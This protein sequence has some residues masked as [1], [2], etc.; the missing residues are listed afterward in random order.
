LDDNCGALAY[1]SRSMY[2]PELYQLVHRGS[3]GDLA[4]YAE[5]C[6]GAGEVLELGCGYGRLLSTIAPLVASYW[7]LDRDA[8]L[9]RL[10]RRRR[11]RLRASVA[12]RISLLRGD[13][14]AFRFETR[15]DRILIPHSGLFCLGSDAEVLA[16]LRCVRRHLSGAGELVIDSYSADAF[17]RDSRP[18]DLP[19][20]HQ[21]WVKRVTLANVQYDVYES[22][23]WNRAAQRMTVTYHH[24]PRAGGRVREAVIEHRYLLRAQLYALLR[25]AGLAP[26]H[27]RGGF[28]GERFGRDSETLV[29]RA[30]RPRRRRMGLGRAAAV[31]RGTRTGTR[32]GRRI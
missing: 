18:S 11:A 9:L 26:L 24:V 3:P 29:V 15:F 10:A 31:T 30:R 7:G 6:R 22:S 4:F 27:S 14:R 8:G 16:C 28:A 23:S 19:D 1:G 5:A 2:E 12:S 25:R 17:H 21:E 32:S 13:M 20:D